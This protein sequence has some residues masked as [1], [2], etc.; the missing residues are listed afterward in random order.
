MIPSFD[1]IDL[2]RAKESE[3]PHGIHCSYTSR[4]DKPQI[5]PP[6]VA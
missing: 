5:P 2:S 6:E 3:C 1:T 4:K